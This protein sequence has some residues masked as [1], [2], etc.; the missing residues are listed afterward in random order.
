M[1]A[2]W[3]NHLS[4]VYLSFWELKQSD[5]LDHTRSIA[6]C[7]VPCNACIKVQLFGTVVISQASM[8]ELQRWKCFG[9]MWCTSSHLKQ[10]QCCE[11]SWRKDT[12][13][14]GTSTVVP[15]LVTSGNS[16][17]SC[18][19][20]DTVTWCTQLQW[21]MIR[22]YHDVAKSL[23][24]L[25]QTP[26]WFAVPMTWLCRGSLSRHCRSAPIFQPMK[27]I[28]ALWTNWVWPVWV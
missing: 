14:A 11:K 1:G 23:T 19:P 16:N 18:R 2:T 15:P 6:H 10:I 4:T 13:S 22:T 21:L 24:S 7:A 5:R 28:S 25:G 9:A 17:A 27:Q 8:K 20:A 3:S 26:M 12:Q